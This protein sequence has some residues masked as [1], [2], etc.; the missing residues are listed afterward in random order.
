MSINA[1][2]W[3]SYIT[4]SLWNLT[5]S[6]DCITDTLIFLRAYNV[7]LFIAFLLTLFNSHNADTGTAVAHAMPTVSTPCGLSL[8]PVNI[9][10]RE[11]IN[12]SINIA[13][14][15]TV[16][17]A[18]SPP[19]AYTE[20]WKALDPG[21][22]YMLWRIDNNVGPHLSGITVKQGGVAIIFDCLKWTNNNS[23]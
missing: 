12:E 1:A 10:Y 4:R 7:I 5:T 8:T 22:A 14:T 11:S 9:T 21:L 19:D 18:T 13:R 6:N 3:K 2:S 23:Q 15:T 20:S 17:S 16:C